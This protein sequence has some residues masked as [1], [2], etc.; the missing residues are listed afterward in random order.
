MNRVLLIAIISMVV[1]GAMLTLVQIWAP[2]V[3]AWEFFVKLMIT[4]VI[5]TVLAAL[6]LVLVSDLQSKKELKDKNYLD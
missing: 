6:V 4:L 3:I 5:L 2:G 1:A